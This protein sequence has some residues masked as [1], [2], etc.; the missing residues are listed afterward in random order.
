MAE[1]GVPR[2]TLATV[3]EGRRGPRELRP[4]PCQLRESRTI[5]APP[6]RYFSRNA[7]ASSAPAEWIAFTQIYPCV[8]CSFEV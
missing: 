7:V 8:L 4:S 3:S 2:P 1:N 5:L 6:I